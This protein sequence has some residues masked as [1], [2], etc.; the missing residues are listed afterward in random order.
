MNYFFLSINSIIVTFALLL[1]MSQMIQSR[2][3]TWQT[4]IL[5]VVASTAVVIRF[6]SEMDSLVQILL[7]CVNYVIFAVIMLLFYKGRIWR[8]FLVLIY[9]AALSVLCDMMMDG[10]YATVLQ[11]S[12]EDITI[13]RNEIGFVVM[14]VITS[15]VFIILGSL[16]VLIWRI[17]SARRFKPFFLL[18]FVLPV[19]QLITAYSY[20]SY[21]VSTSSRTE[22]WLVGVFINIIAILVLLVYTISQEKKTELEEELRKTRHAM[23]LEQLHYQ[24]IENRREELLK[25]RHDFNN[26]LASINRLIRAG[27]D[28][29]AQELIKTLSDNIAGTKENTYCDIP[30]VNAILAEKAQTCETAGFTLKVDLKFPAAIF[31]EQMHLCSIFGN[32]LDNAISACKLTDGAETPV[33]RLKAITEG[34]Y[35]FIKVENPSGE[36]P[37]K[38]AP[39]R[40][41]GSRILTDFAARY[42]GIYSTEYKDGVFTAM[43]SLLAGKEK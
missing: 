35:L 13:V 42:S 15:I 23:E 2:L 29:S 18:F 37:R 11:V 26:Q 36:P 6:F 27:E 40:G 33:I 39:G 34:E 20:Y 8:R 3:N 10:I 41:Y 19:G 12:F 24:G 17:I 4:A 32:M 28:N 14:G 5:A 43:V 22:V 38:P 25:I 16:S 30:V 31:V 7:M 21:I 1:F 9:F